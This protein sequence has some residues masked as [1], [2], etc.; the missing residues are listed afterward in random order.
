MRRLDSLYARVHVASLSTAGQFLPQRPEFRPG[1]FLGKFPSGDQSANFHRE[2][3]GLCMFGIV[4]L[5]VGVCRAGGFGLAFLFNCSPFL[6]GFF[7][8]QFARGDGPP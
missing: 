1:V 2:R 7:F 6:L 5:C 3:A 4:V 8:G